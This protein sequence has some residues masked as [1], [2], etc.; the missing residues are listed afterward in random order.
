M[1]DTNMHNPGKEGVTW[2]EKGTYVLWPLL[3][4]SVH[5]LGTK[6]LCDSNLYISL[7]LQNYLIPTLTLEP[8]WYGFNL[9]Q[10]SS[11]KSRLHTTGTPQ[12]QEI[13]MVSQ[14][15]WKRHFSL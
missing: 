8:F 13:V 14:N 15:D 10:T 1:I 2:V 9:T 6:F 5:E 4:N 12:F 11:M 3:P 7:G